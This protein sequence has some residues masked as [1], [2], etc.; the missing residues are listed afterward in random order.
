MR[1]H[2]RHEGIGLALEH[3]QVIHRGVTQF[4][5]VREVNCAVGRKAQTQCHPHTLHHSRKP[6][7][8]AQDFTRVSSRRGTQDATIGLNL[9]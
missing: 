8:Y 6:F 5:R 2:R 7:D 1:Y 4:E 3:I 9:R